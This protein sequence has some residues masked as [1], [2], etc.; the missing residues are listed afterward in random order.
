MRSFLRTQ[1]WVA[2]GLVLS[3]S[4]PAQEEPAAEFGE[5]VEV[6]EVLVD[7]LATDRKGRV[8]TGLTAED[9]LI[10]EHG[11][12]REVTSATFYTTRYEDLPAEVADTPPPAGFPPAHLP[13]SRYFVLFFHDQTL[14]STDRS[15]L[16]ATRLRVAREAKAW[17][18][19]QM[20][21]SDWMAVVRFDH[22]LTVHTDFTQDRLAIVEAIEGASLNK[23]SSAL[24]PSLRARRE[25][26]PGPSLTAGLPNSWE[27][28]KAS[29]RVE[30]A[31]RI[32]A[33]AARP[34]IGRKNLV[35]F[36]L[37]FGRAESV[38]GNPDERYYPPMTAA[39]N[40]SNMAV[41]PI[42][43]N[44]AGNQTP[45]NNFLSLLADDTGGTYFNTFNR[46][47]DVLRDI[48]R[49]NT[50][51][52]LLSFKS[53]VPGGEQGYRSFR[54]KARDRKVR[55]RARRGYRYGPR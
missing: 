30:D 24:R 49:Y 47:G 22:S 37:G 9:F 1:R 25:A 53:E 51:Y 17:I 2:L 23:R 4:L 40:D 32:V 18:E 39:L 19:S 26:R 41:Y 50:G 15:F 48:S 33:Q 45:Q 52:Y 55:V 8:I 10:E 20:A 14:E 28:E 6:I 36:T 13:A 7:V 34:I 44:G 31:V 43:L 46:F 3:S 27:I 16:T 54:V 35:L 11:E 21:P 5:T 38:L 12:P 29:L 42:D